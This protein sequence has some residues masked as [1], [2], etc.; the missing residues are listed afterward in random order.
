MHPRSALSLNKTVGGGYVEYC[1]DCMT[2]TEIYTPSQDDS[3][4]TWPLRDVLAKLIEAAE[5]LLHRH[6]YDGHAYEEIDECIR[7]AKT[8][9]GQRSE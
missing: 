4:E 8:R 6:D 2:V 5:I 1:S 9:C 3:V 7:Q